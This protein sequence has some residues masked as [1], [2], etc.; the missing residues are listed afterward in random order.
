[1][2]RMEDGMKTGVVDVGGGFRAAY[3]AGVL[4]YCMASGIRFDCGIGV[5]AGAANLSSYF[6]GQFRRNYRFYTEYAFRPAYAGIRELLAHGSYINLPYI[7]GKLS[8]AGGENPLNYR[9]LSENP[10]V[11]EV[12]ATDALTGR[13]HYFGKRDLKENHYD[14]FMA[15]SCVPLAA[16]AWRI[17]DVPYFDGGLSD[18][19]PYERAFSAGCSRVVIILTRPRLY[20]R[21]PGR[22]RAASRLIREYPKIAEVLKRRSETYNRQ[23]DAAEKLAGEG[24]VLIIAP[25]S[26]DGMETLTRDRG[27][28]IRMYEK[29]VSDAHVLKTWFHNG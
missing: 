27:K 9:A 8:N 6:A 28:I 29:G 25:D 16:K 22:D 20:R 3:G 4:D 17:R 5:S 12:V 11:F 21:K 19:I 24:R 13:P 2:N 1:M 7:Y 15:S 14:I 18:P 23:L 10:A 26:I